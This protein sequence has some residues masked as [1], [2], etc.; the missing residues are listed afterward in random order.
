MDT[1]ALKNQGMAFARG[2][3]WFAAGV[4]VGRGL[5]N[6][7][8][9]MTIAGALITVLGGGLSSM[10]NTNGSITSA[11]SA[12]PSTKGL[13]TSDPVLAAAARQSDPTT[14]VKLEPPPKE[15]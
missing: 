8:T 11:F 1:A 2:G 4:A 9:A 14:K 12:I 6:G 10:A 13:T 5:L 7:D 15:T 3:V